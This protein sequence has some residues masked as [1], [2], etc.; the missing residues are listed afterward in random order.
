MEK[1]FIFAHLCDLWLIFEKRNGREI[2]AYLKDSNAYPYPIIRHYLLIALM[3]G[4]RALTFYDYKVSF[5][6]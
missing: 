3:M 6:L 5:A 2:F 4:N 1:V